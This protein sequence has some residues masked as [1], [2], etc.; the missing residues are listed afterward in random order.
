MKCIE[1]QT[2]CRGSGTST[3]ICGLL[4]D[5]GTDFIIGSGKLSSFLRCLRGWRN[6]YK[7]SYSSFLSGGS[8]YDY[9]Y[10]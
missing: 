5:V 7:R 9:D 4:A 3:T 1:F 6:Y 2:H 10:V 8:Y